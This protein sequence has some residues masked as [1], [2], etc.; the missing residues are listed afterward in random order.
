[1]PR[2]ADHS[3]VA[4][5]L[6]IR[7]R[8]ARGQRSIYEVADGAGISAA[9]ISRI[10]NGSRVPSLQL[11]YRLADHLGVERGWLATGDS[12]ETPDAELVALRHEN[13]RLRRLLAEIQSLA[14]ESQ[15]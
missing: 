3:H 1:M 6:G 4:P 15:H 12:S 8:E 10:E 7:L 5:G 13:E 9:Y 11:I 2:K 14:G